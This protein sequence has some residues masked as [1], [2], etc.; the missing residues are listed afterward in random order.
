VRIG[1][2][3]GRGTRVIW[4]TEVDVG[5]S[6]R[7][8][9]ERPDT[10]SLRSGIYVICARQLDRAGA[11][12]LHPFVVVDPDDTAPI[13][14]QVASN[15][16][17]AYN[18]WGGASMY[19]YNSPNGE[20]S[21]V[22]LARPYDIYD[23]LGCALLGDVQLA[24]WLE[25][26]SYQVTYATNIDTHTNRDLMAGR[27]LFLSNF[28]DEYWSSHMRTNLQAWIGSGV[29]AAFLASNNLYW[30][31]SLD[32][33]ADGWKM[34]CAKDPA[35]PEQYLFRSPQINQ[36]ATEILGV[37]YD[38]FK[39]PYGTARFDWIAQSTDHWLYRGTDMRAGES[40]A[41]L[42]GYEWD[43]LPKGAVAGDTTVLASSPTTP[44]RHHNAAVKQH[45][46]GARVFAAGTNYWSRLLVGGGHWP[47]DPRVEAMTHNLLREFTA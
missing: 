7:T 14:M 22:S 39:H 26:H 2:E 25:R 5:P 21:S 28:H 34:H 10:S 36:P 30:Q 35:H 23:G 13:V 46:S 32:E 33:A 41:G 19:A 42:V 38:S 45:P 9:Y 16:Y 31:V 12:R 8:V 47:T 40:I 4:S 27:R 3:E 1:F 15:T 43:R 29:N 37:D 44:G 18:G 11:N 24:W 17:Q 6:H 20:A